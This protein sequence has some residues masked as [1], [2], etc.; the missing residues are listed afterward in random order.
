MEPYLIPTGDG[1]AEFTEK[2]SSFM[3]HVRRVESEDAAR[4]FIAAMK[5]Q[6]HDA[7]HNC[8]C[9]RIQDGPERYSDDVFVEARDWLRGLVSGAPED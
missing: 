2:R 7:R 1:E 3:G 8:W 9:Y 5:K 4:E 6:Y